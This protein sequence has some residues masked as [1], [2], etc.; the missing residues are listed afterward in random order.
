MDQSCPNPAHAQPMYSPNSSVS[1]CAQ[2][3]ARFQHISLSHG[4]CALHGRH[5]RLA[6]AAQ[7]TPS[8][9]LIIHEKKVRHHMAL[10][11]GTVYS[12]I[13]AAAVTIY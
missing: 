2:P 8:I 3:F 11:N 1:G 10:S 7:G 4:S 5:H 12:Y 6:V 9:S 13:V